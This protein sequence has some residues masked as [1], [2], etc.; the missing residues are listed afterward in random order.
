MGKI[1]LIGLAA[2]AALSAQGLT[3]P[4]EMPCDGKASVVID[5]ESG[6]R[7]RNLVNGL[8]FARGRHQV[9]WDGRAEDGTGAAEG[10]YRVRVITHPGIT[11]AYRGPFAA[12]GERLFSGFGPNHLPCT[13]SLG[14]G[15]RMAFASL[16]TE[17]GN[18]TLVLGLDGRL[19][20]GWGEG[21]NLGNRACVYLRGERDCFW[22]LREKDGHEL[23]F[24]GYSW[25]DR[26]RPWTRIAS[27]KP[28]ELKGAV[29][30]GAKVYVA[31]GL[32]KT[33]DVYAIEERDG[34]GTL[35]F[36]GESEP[37]A[38]AG[39]LCEADGRVI[40]AFRPEQRSIAS[41]GKVLYAV[42]EGASVI[43]VYD[44][45]TR[46][47][48]RTIGEDGGAYAGPWRRNRLVRPTSCALD[49]EGFLWVTE[50]RFN[51]KRIT[52]WDVG[53][54]TCV[55]EKTGSERYGSPGGGMDGEDA[56]HWMAHDTE[57]RYDP[58]RGIDGPVAVSHD[59]SRE[60]GDANDLPPNEARTYRWVRRGGKTYVIGVG[61]A[62]MFWEYVDA[63]RRLKPIGMIGTCGL[64]EHMRF[65][66]KRTCR[67]MLEGYA[68]AFPEL[69][70][71][72]LANRFMGDEDT[73][74][75]WKDR[76]GD[77][78]FDADEFE[79]A[80]H[81]SGGTGYWGFFP[82][83]LDFS[84]A[85]WENGE[86]VILSLKF[87]E[88]SLR[89]AWDARR[90]VPGPQPVGVTPQTRAE[91][92]CARDGRLVRTGDEPFMLGY[93]AAGRL[94][95]YMKNPFVGVHGSQKAELPR[96]GE[97]Q[98]VLF[99]IGSVPCGRSHEREAMAIKNNHGRVF[100]IT[101][102]GI[103][104]DE[105]FTD[106]RMAAANDET[107]IGGE[108]FGGSFE[109][110][111]K[112]GRAV[113]ASGGGGYRLYDVLGL[114]RVEEASYERKFT[115][116]ELVE[117]QQAHPLVDPAKRRAPSAT[118][119]EGPK[120]ARLAN[121]DAPGRHVRLDA[122]RDGDRLR[123][124]FEVDDPS[125]WVNRGTDRFEMFKTGDCVDFQFLR[126]GD[127]VRVMAF[128]EGDGGA[129]VV[130]DFKGALAAANGGR[131]EPH[132]FA[133]PWRSF[134]A[135][136][137]FFPK[138]LD[139]RTVRS[140]R[141]YAVALSVPVS[142]LSAGGAPASLTCDFGVIFGDRDGTI[143]QSRVY[144]SNKETGLV[145]D[146]PGEIMP[147]P[148][149]WGRVAFGA[150]ASG[151]SA[152][153]AAAPA[154]IELR[155]EDAL[156]NPSGLTVRP[157]R[158]AVG[159]VYDARRRRLYYST[160]RGEIS[161]VT[162]EGALVARYR[163]PGAM[164]FERFDTLAQGPA[165]ELYVLAAGDSAR[166]RDRPD[167]GRVY[168]LDPTADGAEGECIATG[169]AAIS[170]HLRNGELACMMPDSS[171]SMLS[172]G[173]RRLRPF[174]PKVHLG[175]DYPCMLDWLPDG[176]LMG[177]IEHWQY[178]IYSEGA[179]SDPVRLFGD[180]EI[181][182]ERGRVVGDDLWV[183]AG[184]TIKR[185]D[186]RTLKPAPGVVYG[187]A[188]GYFIGHVRMNHE[189]RASGICDIGG[190][191]FAVLS[192]ENGAVY[193]FR[194][195]PA[196]WRLVETR[197]LGGIAAPQS[198]V[199]DDE[200]WL[201]ADGLCWPFSAKPLQPPEA[202]QVRQPVRAAAL[203][204]DGKVAYV[205]ETYGSQ[206]EFRTGRLADGEL[207]KE[208]ESDAR[209]YPEG[210]ADP[211]RWGEAT[212]ADVFVLGSGAGHAL[213]GLMKDGLVR[214]LVVDGGGHP[215][216]GA[217][218]YREFR[219]PRPEGVE[220]DF[221]AA[222]KL[223]DGRLLASVGGTLCIYEPADGGEWRFKSS[224]SRLRVDALAAD[225][226][227]LA[228]ADAQAGTLTLFAVENGRFRRLAAADGLA[229]PAKV[230]L[231]GGR[232]AVWERGAQRLSRFTYGER[233]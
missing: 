201:M 171:L 122:A 18:S 111:R 143:N 104:L 151:P 30:V 93:D 181:G 4:F 38:V 188:S 17:G 225:G 149:R 69:S 163:L 33:V 1:G 230:A 105:M 5:D 43:R 46:R 192:A 67:P 195:D 51:P 12:G 72:A 73:I 101:T 123:L 227:V 197:R 90:K 141:G 70:G 222:E 16:F 47:E 115:A 121:W 161:A 177:V 13:M 41:D 32:T 179:A 205:H 132:A 209:A 148:A 164:D 219:L 144:W 107:Y 54:G 221:L 202:V 23:Q 215:L 145:N 189:M 61:S 160:G 8:P 173:T 97:L 26:R 125:P 28:T 39:P 6:R 194:Y 81:G 100:F 27:A 155:R 84:I 138:D 183:L 196:T 207:R 174:A 233:Q 211:Q 96:P 29:Q 187:G 220:G 203:L 83:D 98:G 15:D 31:N 9:E 182:M 208:R 85:A 191:E 147:E 106:C 44:L 213:C 89:R 198:L 34:G 167:A 48:L 120:L 193:A 56:T 119:A 102:D 77:E 206:L 231:R 159:P 180:R 40:A 172:V 80:A 36:T 186:A 152:A 71:D 64:Y 94:E 74:M 20:H 134:T 3:L 110:D 150:A 146:V 49:G 216:D 63:E 130:Y 223:A 87:P 184:A 228:M 178:H 21:W 112:G 78:R 229:E 113:L 226:N 135:E 137:V 224:S 79:F 19:L 166:R 170:Q 114:D 59:E 136:N 218:F 50:D 10:R 24:M 162:R 109:Y 60:Q 117:A 124:R 139:V 200:G 158:Y 142:W 185:Y 37:C 62:T 126:G 11:Y 156:V 169:V 82:S 199:L 65:D 42:E 2:V 52:R 133:S 53:R 88:W 118:A 129:A 92:V 108:S 128:P 68:R 140:D 176:R 210:R 204:P 58:A 7:V 153:A 165:G 131:R 190:G 212:P 232:I 35:S 57:W 25:R 66:R 99:S 103:Y 175:A 45:A 86:P 217:G 154:R 14:G 127:P 214:C 95:W 22:S 168:R 116:K 91:Q 76:D 55:Y 75:L 157:T